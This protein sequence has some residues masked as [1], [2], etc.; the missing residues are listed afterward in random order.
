MNTADG[1]DPFGNAAERE[2]E[3]LLNNAPPP[4]EYNQH[5][6]YVN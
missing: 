5:E 4:Q 2:E 6:K 3:P 1:N